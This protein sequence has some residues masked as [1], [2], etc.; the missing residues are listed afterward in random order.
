MITIN[1]DLKP[2]ITE[3]MIRDAI[4]VNDLWLTKID[5]EYPTTL[6]R[7]DILTTDCN[8]VYVPIEVKLGEAIDGSVGQILGYMKAMN[9]QRGIIIASGFSKRV[10][11]ISKDL[12]IDLI[13]YT[14]ND[15]ETLPHQQKQTYNVELPSRLYISQLYIDNLITNNRCNVLPT[16]M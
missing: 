13:Q 5:T 16:Y 12:N 6:G 7:I 1:L 11:A 14:T 3:Y 15:K 4:D 2:P 10:A 9:A 8:G